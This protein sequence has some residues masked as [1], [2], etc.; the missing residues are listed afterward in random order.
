MQIKIEH[1]SVILNNYKLLDDINLTMDTS[2]QWA[3][4][5]DSGSGKTTLGKAIANLIFH[6]GSITLTNNRADKWKTVFVD[7]QH[8]FKNKQNIS[9]FYHQQRFNS[10]DTE[11]ALSVAEILGEDTAKKN[12]EWLTFFGLNHLLE[13]PLIQLSNGENKRLQL[14]KA[15]AND[16]TLLILDN[17][18]VGLDKNGRVT[19]QKLLNQ[20]V[21]KGRNILLICNPKDFPD[22]ITHVARLHKGKLV[23]QGPRYTIP[24]TSEIININNECIND[25]EWKR[26]YQLTETDFEK[27]VELMDVSIQ[28]NNVSIL[29]KINWCVTKGEKWCV[30]GPN[31][32]GKST[33]LSLITAD[34]PQ[35]FANKIWLFDKRKGSGESIWDI[36]KKIGHI[37]PE[38]H[39][40]FEKGIEVRDAV[41]SGLFDTIGLFRKLS[42]DDVTNVDTWM[43]ITGISEFKNKRLHQLSLGEQRL[44][45]L[46]RALVKSPPLLILDEPC[47]GLDEIQTHRIKSIIEKISTLDKI[48]LIYVSH[49][50][51]DIPASINKF[52]HL[53]NGEIKTMT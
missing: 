24:H 47:Q 46:T 19:L 44:V 45:M 9:Q 8:H 11:N 37:S 17:P 5:G 26:Q 30:S 28:Y 51:D 53:E 7:Q 16:P 13:K 12:S 50:Q 34:N 43:S 32:S 38:L 10:L 1:V 25:I 48:T 18:F 3:I 39:L 31:G 52:L 35:A 33:L 27:A 15:I 20:L 6:H 2:Q 21:D 42:N 36:K 22:C 4:I 41:A 23:A 49:Y 14:I 40:F 29:K